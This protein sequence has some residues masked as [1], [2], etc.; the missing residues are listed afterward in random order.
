MKA[1]S[2]HFPIVIVALL[3]LPTASLIG[4][5]CSGARTHTLEAQFADIIPRKISVAPIIESESSGVMGNW[6]EENEIRNVHWSSFRS[7]DGD[8]YFSMGIYVFDSGE[9]ASVFMNKTR[10]SLQEFQGSSNGGWFRVIRRESVADLLDND[11]DD[12]CGYQHETFPHSIDD[13]ED[14]DGR[15]E[16]AVFFK[17]GAMSAIIGSGM[18]RP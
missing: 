9:K 1:L 4:P 10:S 13:P 15:A 2:K 16:Q 8:V 11:A 7:Q 14:E 12:A 5:S 18:I 3:I 6:H 17:W